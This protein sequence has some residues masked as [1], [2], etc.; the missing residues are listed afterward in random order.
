MNTPNVP[1]RANYFREHGIH[2]VDQRH[3]LDYIASFGNWED[4]LAALKDDMPAEGNVI[5]PEYATLPEGIPNVTHHADLILDRIRQGLATTKSTDAVL[6]LGTPT[7][8]KGAKGS[9]AW[10]N[11]VLSMRR[12]KIEAVTHKQSLLPI[13]LALGVKEPLGPEQRFMRDG[14]AVLICAE[15]YLYSMKPDNKL[16]DKKPQQILAP[17][18]WAVPPTD[19][20]NA[21]AKEMER[22]GEDNYYREQLEKVIGSYLMTSL[23]SVQRVIVSDRG[24]PDLAPYNAV[25][26]RTRH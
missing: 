1:F 11:S 13:E 4:T 8:G 18:M 5:T 12:G 26:D 19:G 17:T 16:R 3:G 22:M 10:H 14:Q 15:L 25:F 2:A 20:P 9:E 24:R 7:P 6:H 21:Y 23:P